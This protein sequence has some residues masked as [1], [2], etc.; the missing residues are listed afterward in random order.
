MLLAYSKMALFDE[1]LV[2]TLVDDEYVHA[3]LVAYFPLRCVCDLLVRVRIARKTIELAVLD[4]AGPATQCMQ[5]FLGR[6]YGSTVAGV[7][8]SDAGKEYG[9]DPAKAGAQVTAGQVWVE[10]SGEIAGTVVLVV[11]RTSI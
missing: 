10:G 2:R 5:A 8:S 7:V 6:R 11:R 1:L 4:T 9:I 3:G